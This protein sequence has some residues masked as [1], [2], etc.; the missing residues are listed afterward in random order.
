M[1]V[2]DIYRVLFSWTPHGQRGHEWLCRWFARRMAC[3]RPDISAGRF[4]GSVD[5]GRDTQHHRAECW[6]VAAKRRGR[7]DL[8]S[9]PDAMWGGWHC[10]ASAWFGYEFHLGEHDAAWEHG[11][12]QFLVPDGVRLHRARISFCH[13]PGNSGSS[14]NSAARGPKRGRFDR[15]YLYHRYDCCVVA[16][17]GRGCRPEE[18]R[19]PG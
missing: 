14:A 18:W 19:V 1:D 10:V 11:H 8:S 7:L 4:V 3:T 9:S 5:G 13:E 2:L 12:G 16:N 15:H 17:A 6:E